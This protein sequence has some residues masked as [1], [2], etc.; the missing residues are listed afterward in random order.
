M[1]TKNL[2]KNSV[3]YSY[4]KLDW[5]TIQLDMKNKLGRDIYEGWLRKI[6]FVEEFTV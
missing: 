2:S 4:N 1:T 5:T 6:E 3:N